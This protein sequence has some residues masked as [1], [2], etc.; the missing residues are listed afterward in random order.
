[1]SL[2]ICLSRKCARVFVTSDTNNTYCHAPEIYVNVSQ[3]QLVCWIS[4]ARSA[5]S[6]RFDKVWLSEDKHSTRRT[7]IDIRLK[8]AQGNNLIV[9]S[10]LF[11]EM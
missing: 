11:V 2:K 4:V 9:L 6:H 1:M 7:G 8:A 3:F 5:A 10:G